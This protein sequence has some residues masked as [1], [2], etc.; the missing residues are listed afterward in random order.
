MVGRFS[1]AHILGTQRTER[2]DLG[3]LRVPVV[4]DALLPGPESSAV[5][6][7]VTLPSSAASSPSG[8]SRSSLS[9]SLAISLRRCFLRLRLLAPL[10]HLM[11]SM[12]SRQLVVV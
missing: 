11:K 10:A 2:F 5:L 6:D 1:S 7:T 8:P 4:V 9:L 12:H 3:R